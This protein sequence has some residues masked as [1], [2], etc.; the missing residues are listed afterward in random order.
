[1]PN[2][3]GDH[4]DIFPLAPRSKHKASSGFVD[5][6]EA[7]DSHIAHYSGNQELSN[8]LVDD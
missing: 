2:N 7:Q 3:P 1:V 8:A 6:H 4:E 5:N